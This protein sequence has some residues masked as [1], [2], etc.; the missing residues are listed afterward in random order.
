M[1]SLGSEIAPDVPDCKC[2]AG[3]GWWLLC[4][5]L[6]SCH[7]CEM[8]KDV[9]ALAGVLISW[10]VLWVYFA[11]LNHFH[12]AQHRQ[13]QFSCWNLLQQF[14]PWI[15]LPFSPVLHG[16]LSWFGNGAPQLS[17]ATEM[18]QTLMISLDEVWKS[19]LSHSL[20]LCELFSLY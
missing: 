18:L 11:F 10:A 1:A 5:V 7:Q 20:V 4:C 3:A 6:L 16:Q 9:L 2:Q 12:P 17:A 8:N 19:V 14:I 15:Y 13:V